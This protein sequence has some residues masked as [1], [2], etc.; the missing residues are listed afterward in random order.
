MRIMPWK[1]FSLLSI[2]FL[3]W[4]ELRGVLVN[5]LYDLEGGQGLFRILV[6]DQHFYVVKDEMSFIPAVELVDILFVLVSQEVV[7]Q[8]VNVKQ[9]LQYSVSDNHEK[10][11][12]TEN[13]YHWNL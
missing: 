2:Q 11:M 10:T 4:K 7:V 1:P 8:R 13:L 12:F 5:V 9:A 6:E 3:I